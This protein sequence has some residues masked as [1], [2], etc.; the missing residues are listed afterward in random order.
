MKTYSKKVLELFQNPKNMGEMKNPDAIGEVGNLSCL[1]PNEKIFFND[2]FKEIKKA[3]KGD[4]VMSHDSSENKVIDKFSRDYKDKI[5]ILKNNLSKISLT[6]E[7]LIYAIKLPKHYKFFRTKNKIKLIPAWYHAE[8][9]E[10][11]DISLYPIPK[12]VKDIKF[13]D[14]DIPKPK[15]D[16]KS[17]NIPKKIPLKSDLLRLFGYFLAE[18]HISDKPCNTFISLAF[19]INEKEYIDDV[20][21][22][23]KKLFNLEVKI[24]EFPYKK[25]TTIG[26]YSAQ[27]ARFFKKLFGNGALNKKLPEFIM[28]LPIDKQKSLIEGFWKGDGYINLNR[29]GPRAGYVTISYQ[30][31]QQIRILLLRQR[32]VSS[33]YIEKEKISK[34]AKHREAYRIHVGQRDSL[35]KISNILEIKYSPKSYESIT[36]WFDSNFLYTPITKIEK[37]NYN[38]KVYNLEIKD[39]HSFISEAFSL[40]NCGDIMKIYLKINKDDNKI[41]DIKFQTMGCIAAIA[42]SSMIT[43]L[44]K[45]KTLEEAKKLSNKDVAEELGGLPPIK[46]H[47]SNLA[48]DA[49]KKAIKNYEKKE[50]KII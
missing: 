1:L 10:K 33:I 26:V 36:S 48:A 30:L 29:N 50:N 41:E 38:G 7:H 40:H 47:C 46:M 13:L 3:N 35:K 5:I 17:K 34:W 9:L 43:E 39:I 2:K 32:I 31:A 28:T 14:I 21:K 20:K 12:K 44:A 11:R 42:T 24:K 22:I 49:L 25:T 15:Y 23:C 37:K 27:L 6:K 19:N 18:G 8:Q 45:G 4:L 16:F